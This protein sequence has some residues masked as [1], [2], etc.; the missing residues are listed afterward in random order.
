MAFTSDRQRKAAFA[1]MMNGSISG[2]NRVKFSTA[3]DDPSNLKYTKE[4]YSNMDPE[5]RETFLEVVI[6]YGNE[7]LVGWAEGEMKKIGGDSDFSKKDPYGTDTIRGS[8]GTYPKGNSID[9]RGFKYFPEEGTFI[10]I[11][12]E[13][14]EGK[15][16]Y[17][18]EIE[19]T[20]EDFFM[21]AG[22][23][24]KREI[25]DDLA[26]QGYDFSEYLD[27]GTWTKETDSKLSFSYDPDDGDV[28]SLIAGADP[29]VRLTILK[30]VAKYGDKCASEMAKRELEVMEQEAIA[31]GAVT[32][33]AM[34]EYD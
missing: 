21:Y 16:I 24:T 29:E 30:S 3:S 27:K 23:D 32:D 14:F 19:Q 33:R 26:K 31:E 17:Y 18:G 12:E 4:L 9:G 7:D 1:N 25:I 2:S 13:K 5:A 28:N 22:Y 8:E 10:S 15:T 6:L 11:E 20:P 34:D